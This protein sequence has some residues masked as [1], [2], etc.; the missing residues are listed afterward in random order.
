MVINRWKLA[1][2][3]RKRH[4]DRPVL[5]WLHVHPG[6]H[7]RAMGAALRDADIPVICVSRSHARALGT[8]LDP[9]GR[10]VT[11]W[12]PNPIP[13]ELHPGACPRD[14]DRLLF[15]SSPHKGL[16]EVFEQFAALRRH[17]PRLTLAVADPGYLRWTVGPP[18]EGVVVLGSL[19]H[20][21]LIDE[22]RRALCLFYPQTSFA[23]TFGLVMAEA[24]AVGTPVLVHAGLGA[25][26][27]VVADPRQRIDGRDPAQILE[28][29]TAWRRQPPAV[30]ANPDFRL[31]RVARN[32]RR[33]LSL[34]AAARAGR[35]T[36]PAVPDP[37]PGA[38]PVPGRAP[39]KAPD[40]EFPA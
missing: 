21:Q 26:D 30:Q 8:F 2:K 37:V 17:L 31:S 11:T 22:M 3:L 1:V 15:A 10:P 40:T 24:N 27:E 6:R 32:W 29:I 20:P 13:D 4:P 14:R 36:I 18:P 38:V 12:I 5:L 23:E 33:L 16:A 28:R 39:E 9:H 35:L 19:S 7:N 34:T 25:N